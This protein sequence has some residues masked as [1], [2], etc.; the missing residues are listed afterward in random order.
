MESSWRRNLWELGLTTLRAY[1]SQPQPDV[2]LCAQD[3]VVREF[4]RTNVYDYSNGGMVI[5]YVPVGTRYA[6]GWVFD[7]A[8]VPGDTF[9]FGHKVAP[10]DHT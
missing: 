9:P 1:W 4:W 7:P 10:D 6:Q 2:F 8:H 3:L 5:A